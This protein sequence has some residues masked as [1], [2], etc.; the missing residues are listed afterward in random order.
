MP[1]QDVAVLPVYRRGVF[2]LLASRRWALRILAGLVLV[3]ACVRLGIWQLD[4][5]DE[6]SARNAVIEANVDSDPVPVDDLLDVGRQ[7]SPTHLWTPVVATGTYDLDGQLV[8][9]LR[10]LDGRP[11]VHVLVPLVTA[12]GTALLV[13]RGFVAQDGAASAVPTVPDPPPDEV[14]VVGR[15]RASEEGRGTGGDPDSGAIRY[16]DVDELAT[17]LPYPVYGAWIEVI[18][19]QP[20][21]SVAPVPPPA[22]TPDAGPHLS[23]AIQWFLFACIGIGGF[24]LLMRAESRLRREDEPEQTGVTDD[25]GTTTT[26]VAR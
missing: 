7:L 14:H 13:D 6:R 25:G 4:R 10:P 24:V 15:V 3:A 9:R 16:I 12:G 17:T 20:S 21:V 22:P 5:N 8:V 19:E 18:E 23:Y 2:R 11:G 26:R 1:A